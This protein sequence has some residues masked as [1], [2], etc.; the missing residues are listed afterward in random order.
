MKDNNVYRKNNRQIVIDKTL[1]T[2][3][4]SICKFILVWPLIHLA[5]S[6]PPVPCPAPISRWTEATISPTP[7]IANSY[8]CFLYG[9]TDRT[10]CSNL[11]AFVSDIRD[12]YDNQYIVG[13]LNGI[14]NNSHG[15]IN[16]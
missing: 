5:T 2:L 7:A 16:P 11:R 15:A 4:Q 10:Q 6:T 14:Y 3:M 8:F 9:T 13:Y 12:T 1:L